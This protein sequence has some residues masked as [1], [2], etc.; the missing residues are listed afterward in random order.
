MSRRERTA[1][2]GRS[3]LFGRAERGRLAPSPASSILP[4]LAPS[5]VGPRPARMLAHPAR[6]SGPGAERAVLTGLRSYR[7]ADCR[8]GT[9]NRAFFGPNKEQGLGEQKDWR[10][11]LQASQGAS[12]AA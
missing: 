12:F 7:L 4:V 8:D 6:G 11:C 1:L 2:T 3:C 10:R 5:K 9:R